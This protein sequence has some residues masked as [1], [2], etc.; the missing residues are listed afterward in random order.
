M[1]EDNRQSCTL[2]N[3]SRIASLP[4]DPNT[5]RGFSAPKRIIVDEASR[6]DAAMFAALRPMLATSKDGQLILISTPNGRQGQFFE[7]WEN[8]QGWERYKVT[9]RECP[10]ISA[11]YLEAEMREL[12]PLLYSQEFEGAFIDPDT[13]AFSSELIDA[14]LQDFEAYRL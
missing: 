2:A 13:A 10:R 5:T 11:E 14:A 12:G 7:I 6:I 9:A 1:L 3:G 8:G 4:G